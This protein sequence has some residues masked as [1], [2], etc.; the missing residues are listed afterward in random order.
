MV[1]SQFPKELQGNNY[2]THVSLRNFHFYP[3][4]N[5]KSKDSGAQKINR[6]HTRC[7]L[8]R[9]VY[10]LF[11]MAVYFI[12]VINLYETKIINTECANLSGIQIANHFI[13]LLLL[14]CGVSFH[15][16]TMLWVSLEAF[17]HFQEGKGQTYINHDFHQA[18]SK[19]SHLSQF[20]CESWF[21][22]YSGKG[23][24]VWCFNIPSVPLRPSHQSSG[25]FEVWDGERES[26]ALSK[27]DKNFASRM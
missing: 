12:L 18:Y 8:V 10:C 6:L 26:V 24:M 14:F 13:F 2:G 11:W 17:C 4:L 1:S 7:E 22:I 3:L 15:K 27:N 25:T 16:E 19:S 9:Y 21:R 20:L 5:N 23:V